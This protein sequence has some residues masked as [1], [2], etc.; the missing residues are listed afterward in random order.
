VLTLA[1]IAV[2]AVSIGGL[3]TCIQLPGLDLAF[4]IGRC[5]PSAVHRSNI[6]FTHAHIDHM[7]SIVHHCA[8][9]S[10]THMPPPTYAV[11]EENVAAFQDLLAVWRRL[12]HSELACKIVSVRPGDEVPIRPGLVAVAFRSPHRVPCIGYGL[13]EE[14]NRLKAEYKGLAE[15]EIR[16]LRQGGAEVSERVRAPIVAFTG[17][18]LIDVVDREAVVREARVLVME[19]T[20]LDDRV[21]VEQCRSKGHIHLDEVIERADRFQNQAILFTHL[22]ARYSGQEAKA[23]L[24]QKLPPVLK[25]RVTLLLEGRTGHLAAD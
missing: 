22:S 19:V 8:T 17:D 23:I 12:D 25:E 10:L 14:K 1:G 9:R 11:P 16:A 3:E 15:R 21:S 13:W 5:P 18:S 20:F 24:D 6:L 7:G 4:D 2:D